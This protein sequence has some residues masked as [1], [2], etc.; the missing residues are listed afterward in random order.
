MADSCGFQGVCVEWVFCIGSDC[1]LRAGLGIASAR[2]AERITSGS[3]RPLA[4]EQP[5]V[6]A[7]PFQVAGAADLRGEGGQPRIAASSFRWCLCL[8]R[9]CDRGAIYY[10]GEQRIRPNRKV[11]RSAEAD[12]RRLCRHGWLQPSDWLGRRRNTRTAADSP[13]Q[14]DRPGDRGA[15]RQDCPDW[16]RFPA[17]LCSTAS[18]ER[19]AVP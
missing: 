7:S 4:M 16:R 15:W 10:V 14:P 5:S 2:P 3:S 12:R 9:R 19:C 17:R 13:P 1:G 8:P 11:A 18:T 6:V